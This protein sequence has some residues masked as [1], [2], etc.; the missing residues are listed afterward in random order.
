[1][2]VSSKFIKIIDFL[3]SDTTIGYKKKEYC[4]KKRVDDD[5]PRPGPVLELYDSDQNLTIAVFTGL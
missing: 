4:D 3:V 5:V 2:V 1:M